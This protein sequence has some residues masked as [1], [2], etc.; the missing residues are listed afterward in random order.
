LTVELTRLAGGEPG[1]ATRLR[2]IERLRVRSRLLLSAL[3][4][5][6]AALGS[7]A[8]CAL[9]SVIGALAA[10]Y[11]VRIV[12]YVSSVVAL[13]VGVIAVAGL[14]VGCTRMVSETRIAVSAMTE[15]VSET[16]AER[17]I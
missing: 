11:E 15:E 3:R 9:I 7:F 8:A 4:S 6:Y 14:V 2:Q 16:L 13:A 10:Y 17:V 5:I 1:H 12:L